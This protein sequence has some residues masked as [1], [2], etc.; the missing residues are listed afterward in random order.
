MGPWSRVRVAKCQ[1]L[2]TGLLGLLLGLAVATMAI[3][4]YF[5]APFAAISRVSLE[6]N[7]YQAVHQWVFCAGVSLAG[8]LI[9]GA[10]FCMAA[11]VRE[12][13]GRMAAGF[14]CFALAFCVLVQVVFWRWRNPTQV[15]DALLDTYDLLYEQAL[16][17]PANTRRRRELGAVQDTLRCCGKPSPLGRQGSME[18][19]L[20]AG[21]LALREDCL[22]GVRN[23]LG[24]H[25]SIWDTL[26]SLGLALTVYAMLLSAFLWATIHLDCRGTYTLTPP[27]APDR[28]TQELCAFSYSQSPEVQHPDTQAP[29]G[30]LGEE[31]MQGARLSQHCGGDWSL[32]TTRPQDVRGSL[33]ILAS[34]EPA[35]RFTGWSL[36]EAESSRVPFVLLKRQE[37]SRGPHAA[38]SAENFLRI[39]PRLTPV[40]RR[41]ENR[42][43]FD[44]IEE[45]KKQMRE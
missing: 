12:A 7:P 34:E 25:L 4:T 8:L 39:S 42:Q 10:M 14:L 21:E 29:D 33:A 18:A 36:R 27:R 19:G 3:L 15:E 13:K 31:D 32:P 37:V 9:L 38:V 6:G 24:T 40:M 26:A 16:Q 22:Q 23:L 17:G 45:V 20:C 5:G 2:V 44:D 11:T 41:D 28:P 30:L 43:P 35:G 1:A